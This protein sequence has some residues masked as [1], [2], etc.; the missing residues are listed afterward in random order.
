MH[1]KS[2]RKQ[3]QREAAVQQWKEQHSHTAEQQYICTADHGTG[4]IVH[5]GRLQEKRVVGNRAAHK[6]VW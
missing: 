4:V 3:T 5:V 6:L 1:Y 2:R